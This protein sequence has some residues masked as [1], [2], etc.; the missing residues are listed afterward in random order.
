MS[1]DADLLDISDPDVAMRLGSELAGDLLRSVG[2][3]LV[4]IPVQSRVLFFQAY[5][6]VLIG[7]MK[8]VVGEDLTKSSF[9][10]L[11]RCL[12]ESEREPKP[13]LH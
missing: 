8:A 11:Q 6:A 2:G 9:D 12:V 10:H 3:G 5:I 1:G 7:G 4:A 13:N